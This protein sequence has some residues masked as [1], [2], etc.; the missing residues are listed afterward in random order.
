MTKKREEPARDRRGFLKCMP[1]VG[2]GAVGATITWANHD[3]VPQHNVVNTEKKFA[4][5]VLN[6]DEPFSHTFDAAGTYDYYRSI[7]PTMTGQV[8]VA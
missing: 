2:T 3:D 8:W 4:S 6:T 7:H 1:W 5:P